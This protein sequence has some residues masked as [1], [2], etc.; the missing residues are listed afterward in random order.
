MATN[1]PASASG[2]NLAAPVF[3]CG[4]ETIGK[5][6]YAVYDDIRSDPE[7]E[8]VNPPRKCFASSIPVILRVD[9]KSQL[10]KRQ[11]PVEEATTTVD[12]PLTGAH[13]ATVNEDEVH[14]E[15]G[16]SM[17]EEAAATPKDKPQWVP[18]IDA[19]S[20]GDPAK[21]PRE[22]MNELFAL[23]RRIPTSTNGK[24]K[25][26]G[27]L[28]KRKTGKVCLHF[29]YFGSGGCHFTVKDSAKFACMRCTNQQRACCIWDADEKAIILLPIAEGVR[30][31]TAAPEDKR[32]WI[33]GKANA[34]PGQS[35]NRK[36]FQGSGRSGQDG[37]G[38]AEMEDE[39]FAEMASGKIP[40]C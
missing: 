15:P 10:D 6:R 36:L 24:D 19:S 2:V 20:L 17:I 25:W 40:A 30:D 33:H 37:E 35:Q 1:L 29:R 26:Y 31:A 3:P 4:V 9:A 34:I 7:I 39:S 28:T 38:A 5:R 13:V 21:V 23:F 32:Y 16:A 8:I 27:N 12:S 22:A 11:R 18:R 14:S